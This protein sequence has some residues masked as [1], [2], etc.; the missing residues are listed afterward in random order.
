MDSNQ[1]YLYYLDDIKEFLANLRLIQKIC[2]EKYNL[3]YQDIERLDDF[4]LY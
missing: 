3:D 2:I 1:I 4:V